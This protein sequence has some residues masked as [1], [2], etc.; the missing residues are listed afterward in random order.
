MQVTVVPWPTAE[1]SVTVPPCSSTKERTIE[2]PRPAPRWSE[3][4]EWVSNQS[5]TRS[6]ISG[7]MPG[8]LS[9]TVNTT[10]SLAPLGR[11]RHGL[12]GRR[13]ADRVGEQ[14]EQHLAHAPLVGDE[15]ADVVGGADIEHDRR[16]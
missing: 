6:C 16:P 10:A 9:V 2:R 13:E 14:I 5:N 8:P 7:G 4:S 15:A 11:K 3:P 1:S 12:A